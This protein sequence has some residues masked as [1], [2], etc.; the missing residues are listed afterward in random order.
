MIVRWKLYDLPDVRHVSE[1]DQPCT[2]WPQRNIMPED[3]RHR[4]TNARATVNAALIKGK[5]FSFGCTSVA[6]CDRGTTYYPFEK[7]DWA[8]RL[9]NRP[10]MLLPYSLLLFHLPPDDGHSWYQNTIHAYAKQVTRCSCFA[11]LLFRYL[12]NGITDWLERP[13]LLSNGSFWAKI[14]ARRAREPQNVLPLCT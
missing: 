12:N 3:A 6:C 1:F 10:I 5:P 7:T 13:I 8:P 4:S 9:K 2:E 11:I 14:T